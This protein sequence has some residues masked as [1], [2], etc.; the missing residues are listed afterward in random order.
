MTLEEAAVEAQ[1][2]EPASLDRGSEPTRCEPGLT[3]SVKRRS[4]A[5]SGTA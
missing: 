4:C 5:W 3:P 1:L 2:G